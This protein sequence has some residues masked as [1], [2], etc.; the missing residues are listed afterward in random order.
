MPILTV[1]ADGTVTGDIFEATRPWNDNCAPDWVERKA[2]IAYENE[3]KFDDL[4][5]RYRRPTVDD[6]LIGYEQF[7]QMSQAI[8]GKK[9]TPEQD[10]YRR[11][12]Y[13]SGKTDYECAVI[14][15]IDIKQFR[16]WR[17][18]RG[19]VRKKRDSSHTYLTEIFAE[20]IYKWYLEGKSFVDMKK[21]IEAMD[22]HS[23]QVNVISL[24]L[25][26]YMTNNGIIPQRN[27]KVYLPKTC[28]YCEVVFIPK[29]PTQKFCSKSCKGKARYHRHK[30]PERNCIQCGKSFEP[31][32]AREIICSG[33]CKR[34][35]RIQQMKVF[36]QKT[37]GVKAYATQTS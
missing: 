20:Q 14:L 32:E 29:I 30:I 11:D 27:A 31:R 5:R 15:G 8:R 12:L 10:Q 2:Q 35:R 25:Q 1:T 36:H 22:E 6:I 28:P 9:L 18:I 26:E 21:L 19:V 7:S 13:A 34:A 16:V 24:V 33:E 37:R 3:H 17:T 23:P 4:P